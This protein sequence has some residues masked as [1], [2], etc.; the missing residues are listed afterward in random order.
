MKFF[1]EEILFVPTTK[2]NLQCPHCN[3]KQSDELLPQSL[4]LKF[5]K[6]CKRHQINKIGFTGGE[7]FLAPDF[8]TN[9]VKTAVANKMCFD[10]IMTNAVWFKNRTV[11]ENTL[12]K[13][14][15]AGYDGKLSI[16]V[17]SFHNQNIEKV[18]LF[19][20]TA[21]KIFNRQDLIS[22]VYTT[23]TDNGKT[24]Q[25]LKRLSALLKTNFYKEYL[26]NQF[27][28][29]KTLKIDLSPVGKAETLANPWNGH[30]FKEDYCQ[31][32]GN[33]FYVMPNGDVYPCCGYATDLDINRRLIIGNIKCNTV[34]EIMQNVKR[35]RFVS[36][37]F[38]S[39]LSKIRKRLDKI[40]FKFPGK[41][42][43]HCYFCYYILTH[44]LGDGLG[45]RSSLIG[46]GNNIGV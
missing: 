7:P 18:V 1:P 5:L 19:I 12:T 39:G 38:H 41:T 35:N 14:Y 28:F 29:I 3:V 45:R 40:G 4:A 27:L 20:K 33:I 21:V 43:N 30:W 24:Q 22:L 26:K 31:G 46:N 11:L 6:D 23:G 32:P 2:C 17:D 13:L 15:R 34:L 42:R 37:V 25:K 8:L 36:T 16:S 10:R 9:I 44:V